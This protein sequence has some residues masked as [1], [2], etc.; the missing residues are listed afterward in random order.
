MYIYLQGEN[1]DIKVGKL[2]SLMNIVFF[3]TDGLRSYMSG[4]LSPVGVMVK[5]SVIGG[6]SMSQK[7]FKWS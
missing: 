6:N 1:V 4:R 2:I 7:S 3:V 5:V